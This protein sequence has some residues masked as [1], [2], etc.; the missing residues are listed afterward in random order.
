MKANQTIDAARLDQDLKLSADVVIVGTGAGGGFAAETLS[1]AGLKVV[2]LEAGN[3]NT[4]ATFSQN[5]GVSFP[6]LYQ[7]GGAQRTK[8]KAISVFQGRSVGGTTVVN[9]TSSFR[10]PH[11]TLAHW[12]ERYGVPDISV[13]QMAPYFEEVEQRLSI[14]PWESFP[15]NE[16]NAALARGCEKL[17]YSHS[18]MKRNVRGCANTGLC[19]L[20]CPINAKQSML[21]TTVP[22]AL[23]HGATLV[24]RVRVE[25]IV[26]DGKRASGVVGV[27]Y[28]ENGTD[29]TTRRVEVSARHVVA[30]AGSIRTPGLLMRSEVPDP[31]GMTGQRTFLHPVS[32]V[33]AIMPDTVD[34][35]RG[36]PQST[37]SDHF[38]WPED[39][40]IGFKLETTPLQPVF[41]IALFDKSLG[42]Q[43]G[44][45]VR[46]FRNLHSE[47]ALLRDGFDERA[48]GGSVELGEDGEEVLD[49]PVTDYVQ[50]GFLRG[51]ETMIDVQFAAGAESVIPWHSA[52]QPLHSPAEARTWLAGRARGVQY[53]SAHVMGG[54]L[55]G[56]EAGGSVVDPYGRH[57]SLAGLSV[58]DGS[59]FPTS[60]GANPQES[61]YGFSLRNARKLAEDLA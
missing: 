12:S 52:A 32:G 46:K 7:Q 48:P 21:V 6:M 5:E 44:D 55:M 19:G 2:M 25:R 27:A 9:W 49:Y 39:D 51:L 8:D 56:A 23:E 14:T 59:I 31:S 11:Q 41:A 42:T 35:W 26:H 17:G 1:R 57:H 34:G 38:L 16:N 22:A 24:Y 20:G 18:R 47:I 28:A 40:R 54:A 13:E 33:L 50:E 61:I 4:A 3:Y 30:A 37:Y 60:I 36:A 58:I 53:G 29:K 10:T 43:H 15:P 45:Y